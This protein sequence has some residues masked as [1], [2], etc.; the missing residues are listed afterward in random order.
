M[1]KQPPGLITTMYHNSVKFE[2]PSH[3]NN[4]DHNLCYYNDKYIGILTNDGATCSFI[5]YLPN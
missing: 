2:W 4:S 3:Q 1:G 5:H